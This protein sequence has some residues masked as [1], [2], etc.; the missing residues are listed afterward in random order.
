MAAHS[1][2]LQD[3]GLAKYVGSGAIGVVA[4]VARACLVVG[5]VL[6]FRRAV[7]KMHKAI[8]KPVFGQIKEQRGFRR[9]SLRSKQ[10]V[11]REWKLVCAVSN[12]LK[13]FRA[14]EVLEMAQSGGKRG[15]FYPKQHRKL[16]TRF[17][18]DYCPRALD[19]TP[20][21]QTAE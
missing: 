4:L 17:Q 21:L 7:Y 8:V 18:Q 11:S 5:F 6:R 20:A 9:F 16:D 10:N 1:R 14:G 15:P 19:R 2:G 3:V 12:L 13:L